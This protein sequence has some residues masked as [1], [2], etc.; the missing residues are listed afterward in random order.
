MNLSDSGARAIARHEGMVLEPYNDPAG[1]RRGVNRRPESV[2]QPL[3]GNPYNASPYELL[4]SLHSQ[5]SF[6]LTP[7]RVHDGGFDRIHDM[8]ENRSLDSI[9]C[10]QHRRDG[11]G[12]NG[13]SPSFL[14]K[15]LDS[16]G[17]DGRSLCELQVPHEQGSN[18]RDFDKDDLSQ[19]RLKLDLQ[20][21][22][23]R[24]D[25]IAQTWYCRF[26]CAHSLGHRAIRSI[27]STRSLLCGFFAKGASLNRLWDHLA[28]RMAT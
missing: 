2:E 1:F 20:V 26:G 12:D 14:S 6:P 11:L 4:V 27:P 18:K 7:C 22:C 19:D 10:F 25:G 24:L 16:R 8:Y 9:A 5:C 28:L 13:L 21:L 3:S 17:F 15:Q 23:R